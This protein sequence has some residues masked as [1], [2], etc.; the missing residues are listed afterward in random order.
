MI[1]KTL[2]N[3][4]SQ[5]F[6]KIAVRKNF[7]L[8]IVKETPVLKFPFNKVAGL[9]VCIFIKKETPTHLFSCEYCE[10]LK[11]RFF[12]ERLTSLGTKL[13]FFIFLVSLL[14]FPS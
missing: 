13:V 3:S 1:G 6:F 14:C 11:K 2:R 7:F 5:M 4:R 10:I 8:N 12:T 9:K